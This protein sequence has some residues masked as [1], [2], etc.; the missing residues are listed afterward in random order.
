MPA[1]L[2]PGATRSQRSLTEDEKALLPFM[3][4]IASKMDN[5]HIRK[6]VDKLRDTLNMLQNQA[7]EDRRAINNHTEE[8][9]SLQHAV[10]ALQS[11]VDVDDSS[12]AN[13]QADIIRH[14]ATIDE[15]RKT[16]RELT[17]ANAKLSNANESIANNN[18]TVLKDVEETVRNANKANETIEV[19]LQQYEHSHTSSNRDIRQQ[20]GDTQ[21][22]LKILEQSFEQLTLEVL[23]S[24][25]AQFSY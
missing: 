10:R 22:A 19:R 1:Q 8:M 9:L 17:E 6:D 12:I 4:V 14:N 2:L 5:V 11:R 21:S 16:N 23:P 7:V 24:T 25:N 20:L 13:L 3:T 18:K 15:L